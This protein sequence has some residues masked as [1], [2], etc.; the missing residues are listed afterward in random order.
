MSQ[1]DQGR[2][3]LGAETRMECR[4]CWQVYDPAAGDTVQQIPPGTAFLDLPSYWRCPQ[5]DAEPA[6]YLPMD[7]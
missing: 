4:I 6:A 2:S 5:C 3:R 7:D 1:A